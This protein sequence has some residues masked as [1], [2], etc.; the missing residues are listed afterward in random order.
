VLFSG[1]QYPGRIPLRQSFAAAIAEPDL[2][3]CQDMLR[4][5][6]HIELGLIR[7]NGL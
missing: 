3:Q 2:A 1:T 5:F 4:F 7:W 6:S